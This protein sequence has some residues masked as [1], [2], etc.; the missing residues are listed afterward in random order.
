VATETEVVAQLDALKSEYLP[1]VLHDTEFGY[2]DYLDGNAVAHDAAC[3]RLSAAVDRFTRAGSSYRDELRRINERGDS[4]DRRGVYILGLVQ[5][6]RADYAS[7]FLRSLEELVHADPFADFLAMAKELLDKGFK[8]PAAVLA[9][10]VLES[11]I[12]QLASR[13]GISVTNAQ[14]KPRSA[15]AINADLGKQIYGTGEQKSVTA[16]LDLRNDAA[17]GDYEKYDH[18]Q[19]A[20]LIESV[21]AFMGRWPA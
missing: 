12:R 18:K 3:A 19:V 21:R 13:A 2:G 16:W 14:A 17:H 7:G 6:L 1:K 10:S 8:D 11:H 20:L 9:G 4:S 15:E 5:G